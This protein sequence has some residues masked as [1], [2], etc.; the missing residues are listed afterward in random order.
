MIVEQ[1]AGVYSGF[2]ACIK[3]AID[4][5]CRAYFASPSPLHAQLL[6]EGARRFPEN[7]GS[8]V[9]AAHPVE[10]LAMALG[11][12][13]AGLLP[14]VSA[15]YPDFLA[16]QEVLQSCCQSETPVVFSLL[17]YQEPLGPEA[18]P[19]AYPYP[20]FLDPWPASGLPLLSLMP[21]NL[22]QVYQLTTEACELA[23]FLRQ[24]VVLLLDPVLLTLTGPL[25]PSLNEPLPRLLPDSVAAW[26]SGAQARL[27]QL[28]ELAPRWLQHWPSNQ[29]S[30]FT[31]LAT[32][33]LG[34][35][36]LDMDWED[37]SVLVPESLYPLACQSLPAEP[38]YVV[39]FAPAQLYQRLQQRFPQADLRALNLPW[40]RT[41]PIGLQ[42]Q[43]LN[44]LQAAEASH[45]P[46]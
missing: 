24:P 7:H 30:D 45:A 8:F 23:L 14:L 40:Q 4:G 12:S 6:N 26:P 27:A 28:A 19:L 33:A 9:Q 10:A 32:G 1:Q 29:R 2:Q 16:M 34:G 39:E 43:L 44:S 5:G 25:Q 42:R 3:G 13:Q 21:A 22:S 15:N 41:A 20:C 38:V 46:Q 11:A 17:L 37:N 18:S 36:I 31:L 35:W